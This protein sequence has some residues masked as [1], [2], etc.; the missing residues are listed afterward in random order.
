MSNEKQTI[1]FKKAK[2]PRKQLE[3]PTLHFI[4]TDQWTDVLS[5]KA[6]FAWL[7]MYSW[8]KRDEE[9]AEVNLWEQSKIPYSFKSVQKKL[10]VGNDTFYNKILKPLWNVGLIDIEEYE[11]S[12]NKGTKPMNIIVYKYPQNNKALAYEP[13]KEIRDYD[14][15]YHS[16]ARTFAKKGGRPKKQGGSEREHPPVPKENT[17]LFQKRT[18]PRSEIEHINIFNGF[19]NSFNTLINTL[20]NLSNNF[21]SSSL[22]ESSKK[23]KIH[24]R[25]KEE[26]E[27]IKNAFN[28]NIAYQ[29]LGEYLLEKRIDKKTIGKTILELKKRNLGLFSMKDV[30]KQFNHMMDK[31]TYGEIDNHNGFAAYFA[32]GLQMR[33]SQ[34]QAS[35]QHQEEMLKRYE[36]NMKKEKRDTSIYYNWIEEG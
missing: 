11:Q 13:I 7:R 1:N 23:E 24:K 5:E 27:E 34:S 4:V 6:I 28:Q 14:T 31:L 30:E 29:V 2:E 12:E 25:D 26:K 9:N 36:D 19:N 10:K 21:N 16:N 15:D 22:N 17:P 8:C 20:N 18:P 3:L 33:N 35:K 32:N